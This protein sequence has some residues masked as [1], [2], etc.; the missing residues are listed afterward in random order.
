[1]NLICLFR[2]HR[3]VFVSDERAREERW[4]VGGMFSPWTCARCSAEF[5]VEIPLATP[6]PPRRP[7]PSRHLPHSDDDWIEE[8]MGAKDMGFLKTVDYAMD[9][10]FR[11]AYNLRKELEM[12]DRSATMA[13]CALLVCEERLHRDG[14]RWD[15]SQPDTVFHDGGKE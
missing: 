14:W 11:I 12:R 1:M 5:H 6:P 13:E 4:L 15:A 9:S 3:K 2:G 8:R 10:I 7:L